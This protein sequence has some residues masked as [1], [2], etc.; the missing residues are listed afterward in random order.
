MRLSL[1]LRNMGETSRPAPF[2]ACVAAAEDSAVDTVWLA[3]HIAIPPDDAEGSG[4]RYLDP[5]AC[6]AYIAGATQRLRFGTGVLVLPYRPPLATAKWVATIQELSG[7]RFRLGVG[8]G[9]MEAEFAAVGARLS[10]RARMTDE[11]L[12]LIQRA[13]A[14]D[15][16]ELNGRSYL[17]LPRP[18]R[19]QVLVGGRAPYAVERAARYGDG[20]MP[21][22]RAPAELAPEIADLRRRFTAA[23][24]SNPEV[25]VITQLAL[26]DDGLAREQVAELAELGATEIV[27][28]WRYTGAEEF[29]DAAQAL[30][31]LAE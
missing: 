31:R 19:P 18:T 22:G 9:W 12:D 7:E 4:G 17:F 2:A 13:F 25:V 28:A 10:Q 21:F 27:H 1:Y 30:S 14:D 24:K 26:G 3:D 23:G 29:G 6:A 5:L 8:V 16:V 11:V 20:W 15:T